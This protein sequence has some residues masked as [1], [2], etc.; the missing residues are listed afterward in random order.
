[1]RLIVAVT[2]LFVVAAQP[3]AAATTVFAG[4]VYQTTGTVIA[5]SNALGAP[6]STTSTILRTAGAGSS[7]VLLMSK[8]TTGVST[9]L[10][11]QRQTA[12][13]SVQIAIGEVI[14][15]VATFSANI[16]LPGGFG[17]TYALDLT[18]ACASISPTGCSLLR[19]RVTGGPG[20]GFLLDGVSGVAAAPEP[21]F[22][23]LAI[24]G[25]GGLAW[26][27]NHRRNA[28]R[29]VAA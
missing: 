11:G 9:M 17:P 27:L 16:A 28:R 12:G 21:S 18:A 1:M 13:T 5:P 3:A 24:V 7:L 25:F 26:R 14:G 8:A 2:T 15:G 20:G 29:L 4:S 6:D 10:F 19:I 23:L 22:W